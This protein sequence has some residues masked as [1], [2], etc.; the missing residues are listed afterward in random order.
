MA[1][2]D[3]AKRQ[4]QDLYYGL[5][6]PRAAFLASVLTMA[7]IWVFANRALPHDA[8]MPAITS[9]MFAL[10]AAFAV[11]AWWQRGAD[12][13]DVTYGDVAGAMALIGVCMSALIGP[14]QMV[15]VVVGSNS[16]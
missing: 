2:T 8:V 12:E 16:D 9:A 10:A 14:E 1:F 7:A 11:I 4:S 5:S 13:S 15:R 6:G 3:P